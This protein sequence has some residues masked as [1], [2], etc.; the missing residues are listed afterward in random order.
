MQSLL[1]YESKMA[2]IFAASD[3][4]HNYKFCDGI[5]FFPLVYSRMHLPWYSCRLQFSR[6]FVCSSKSAAM[7]SNSVN[8]LLF[9]ILS[10]AVT[11][12]FNFCF[13]RELQ[14]NLIKQVNQTAFI[15]LAELTTL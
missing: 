6:P 10:D 9:F 8:I 13:F 7:D 3:L 11:S 4:Y 15:N 1:L 5:K 12:G 14:G 2:F